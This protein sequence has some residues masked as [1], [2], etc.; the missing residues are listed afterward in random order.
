MIVDSALQTG[1][2]V[3]AEEHQVHGGLGS[4]VA[5][6]VVRQCPVPMEFV[7]VMDTFGESGKP[8]ELLQKYHIKAVDIVAAAKKVVAKKVAV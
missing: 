6:V 2:I 4:A 8:D 1:A 3:T 5:E 7:A